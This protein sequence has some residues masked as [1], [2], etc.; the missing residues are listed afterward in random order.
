LSEYLVVLKQ[1]ISTILCQRQAV[2]CHLRRDVFC[3]GWYVNNVCVYLWESVSF[4]HLLS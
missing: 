3:R 4:E 1:L 2:W